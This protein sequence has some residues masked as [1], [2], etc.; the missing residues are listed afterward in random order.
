[1]TGVINL[2][3]DQRKSMW[4]ASRM[5]LWSLLASLVIL[6]IFGLVNPFGFWNSP[7]EVFFVLGGWII[8]YHLLERVRGGR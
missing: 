8:G 1:M 7:K 5:L 2:S 3:V 4:R 6:A